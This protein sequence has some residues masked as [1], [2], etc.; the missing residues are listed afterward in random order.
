MRTEEIKPRYTVLLY[1]REERD[2]Y[3]VIVPSLPGCVTEGDTAEEALAMAR[4]AISGHVAALRDIGEDVPNEDA[5]PIIAT[6]DADVLLAQAA[7]AQAAPA[8]P[9]RGRVPSP[10]T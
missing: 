5:P 10:A 6:V 2:G 3:V 1:P 4:D 7:A 9:R 8:R